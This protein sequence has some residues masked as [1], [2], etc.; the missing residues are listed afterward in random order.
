MTQKTPYSWFDRLLKHPVELDK[1]MALRDDFDDYSVLVFQEFYFKALLPKLL[2]GVDKYNKKNGRDLRVRPVSPDKLLEVKGGLKIVSAGGWPKKFHVFLQ[3]AEVDC[4]LFRAGA[5]LGSAPGDEVGT[6]AGLFAS[7]LAERLGGCE[8]RANGWKFVYSGLPDTD[9]NSRGTFGAIAADIRA[10]R[11]GER[12][13][14]PEAGRHV[15]ALMD[16][17]K[18]TDEVALE[19]LG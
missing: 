13:V 7:R 16:I 14:L 2:A 18:I 4:S 19:T 3:S 8:P 1:F 11:G 10:L 12:A 17:V 6:A 5:W 9:W 15:D